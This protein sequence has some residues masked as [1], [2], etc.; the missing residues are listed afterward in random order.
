MLAPRFLL[1]TTY[2]ISFRA[3]QPHRVSECVFHLS[4]IINCMTLPVKCILLDFIIDI[5]TRAKLSGRIGA[6]RAL[7]HTQTH[8]TLTI[9]SGSIQAF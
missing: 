9:E 3:V 4:A 8:T 5:K 7:A 6:K 1:V 2:N